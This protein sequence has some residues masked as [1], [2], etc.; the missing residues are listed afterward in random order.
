MMVDGISNTVNEIDAVRVPV[1]PGNEHGTGFTKKVTPIS[2]EREGGRNSDGSVGRVWQIA[3][4]DRTDRLGH[5]TSYVLYPTEAPTLLADPTSVIAARAA[6]ATKSLWVTRYHSE[7][8]YPA[9]DFVNQHPG[10]AGIPAYIADD[11]P[12]LGEDL[13]VW[14]TFGPTHFPRNEDWPV[15]PVDYAKFTLKPYNFFD[16]SPVLNIPAPQ[17]ADGP[18]SAGAPGPHGHCCGPES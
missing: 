10:G 4:A 2:S 15:M 3:S 6:F 5:P 13:V 18:A 11:E 7:E 1:G 9:G 14:H 8:R 16:R 17:S 12:L